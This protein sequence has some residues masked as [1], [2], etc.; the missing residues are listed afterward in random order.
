MQKL[1]YEIGNWRADAAL[2]HIEP[3]KLMAVIFLS[4][5]SAGEAGSRHTIVFDHV[6]G[7]DAADATEALI[8]HLVREHYGA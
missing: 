2:E 6:D 8:R 5:R 4:N 7:L 3:D 1:C